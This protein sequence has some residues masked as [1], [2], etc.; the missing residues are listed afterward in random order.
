VAGGPPSAIG[1]FRQPA[2]RL[3]SKPFT[4]VIYAAMAEADSRGAFVGDSASRATPTTIKVWRNRLGILCAPWESAIQGYP[5]DARGIE[6]AVMLRFV[7]S[8][9]AVVALV[10]VAIAQASSQTKLQLSPEQADVWRGELNYYRYLKAKDLNGFMSLWDEKF[11]GWPDFSEL[12]QHRNW[13]GGRIQ[14]SGSGGT[15]HFRACAR[16]CAGLWRCCDYVLLLADICVHLPNYA[17]L[18]Q[19]TSRL[20]NHWRDGL[21]GSEQDKIRSSVICH[22]GIVRRC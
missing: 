13:G 18:A 9:C 19:R 15:S 4:F 11:V 2:I 3:D 20:A 21:R 17:H 22:A 14:G 8:C 12:P 1:I 5:P 10:S 7:T 6:V 16:S